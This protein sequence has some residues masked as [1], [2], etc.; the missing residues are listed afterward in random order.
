VKG[1]ALASA[2]AIALLTGC[3][4]I[5]DNLSRNT[6]SVLVLRD[7][8]PAALETITY[9]QKP[10]SNSLTQTDREGRVIARFSQRWGSILWII[11]PLGY[12]PRRS[13]EPVYTFAIGTDTCTIAPQDRRLV[14]TWKE[15]GWKIEGKLEIGEPSSPP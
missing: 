9:Q 14:Y 4:G 6:V 8:K 3:A 5:S 1:R 12:L 13:R 10:L 2:L 11:P 15:G 7:E